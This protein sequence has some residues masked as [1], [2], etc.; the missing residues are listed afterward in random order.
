MWTRRLRRSGCRRIVAFAV[1]ISVGVFGPVTWAGATN[2]TAVP[3]ELPNPADA[4]PLPTELASDVSCPSAVSCTA[5][6]SYQ[7]TVGITHAMTLDL[8]SGSWSSAE[9]LA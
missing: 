4:G 5:V 2:S 6:G 3:T 9:M 8:A 7:D 1:T